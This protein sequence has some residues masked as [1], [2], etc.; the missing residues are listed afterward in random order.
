MMGDLV[1]WL[2]QDNQKDLFEVVVALVLNILFLALAALLL[3]PLD[4]LRLALDLAK[5]YG[6]LWVVTSIVAPWVRWLHRR[7]RM[8][9][10]H[11]AN[12]YILSNL[13]VSCLLQVA[14]SAFA[15]LAVRSFVTGVPVWAAILLYVVGVLSCLSAFFAVSA[16]YQGHIYKL[17]SMPI[18]LV[19]FLVFSVWPASGGAV[20]G[21]FL[22]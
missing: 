8:D 15:A 10:Y 5:G 16:F 6:V 12:V 20:F 19:G 1:D 13:A 3:W 21:W 4:R 7:L 2:V 17:L 14:W 11:R 22:G 9:L 18:A